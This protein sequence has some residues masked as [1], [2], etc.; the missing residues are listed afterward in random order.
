MPSKSRSGYAVTT[1]VIEPSLS[2]VIQLVIN[3]CGWYVILLGKLLSFLPHVN[4]TQTTVC[5]SNQDIFL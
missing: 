2:L 1:S 3:F 5:S 4:T